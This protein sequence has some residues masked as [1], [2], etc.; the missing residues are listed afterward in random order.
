MNVNFIETHV[1]RFG[2]SFPAPCRLCHAE[3]SPAGSVGTVYTSQYPHS[4]DHC[5]ALVLV[6]AVR[7]EK[8]TQTT[9]YHRDPISSAY[10]ARV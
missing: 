3:R 6:R 2:S 1:S 7:I 4:D 10:A 5:V 9:E 8:V